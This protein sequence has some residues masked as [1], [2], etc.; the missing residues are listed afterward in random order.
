MSA[1]QVLDVLYGLLGHCWVSRGWCGNP[2][3]LGKTS[4]RNAECFE[5]YGLSLV[6][7]VR[8]AE[9]NE[10]ALR[11]LPNGTG[12]RFVYLRL[13]Q[14]TELEHTPKPLPTG[15]KGIP[16]IVG[17]GDCLGCALGVCCNF[18]GVKARKSAAS[19][20]LFEK[21]GVGQDGRCTLRSILLLFVIIDHPFG[22]WNILPLQTLEIQSVAINLFFASLTNLNL[23]P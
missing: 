11:E 20:H 19:A 5:H 3:F 4:S 1:R 23:E 16:F 2:M 8:S 18:L 14:H 9:R 17:Q 15:Y 7:H 6:H 22:N 12:F 21:F 10:S 13:F